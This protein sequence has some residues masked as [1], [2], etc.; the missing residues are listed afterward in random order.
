MCINADG[1]EN[2]VTP[3]LT[4]LPDPYRPHPQATSHL[5]ANVYLVPDADAAKKLA[6]EEVAAMGAKME[7]SY[8]TTRCACQRGRGAKRLCGAAQYTKWDTIAVPDMLLGR[9]VPTFVGYTARVVHDALVL[10]GKREAEMGL[11][12]PSSAG[13]PRSR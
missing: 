7:A 13:S 5:Y 9:L 11:S 8:P 10:E 12:P 4:A 1:F 2:S 3:P 6:P